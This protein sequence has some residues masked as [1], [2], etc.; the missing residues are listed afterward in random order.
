GAPLRYEPPSAEMQARA[1]SMAA[2]VKQEFPAGLEK[3]DEPL[4]SFV[5]ELESGTA[6]AQSVPSRFS[7][8]FCYSYF[9]LYGDPL[10]ERDADPHPEG[11]LRKLAGTGVDG[12]WLQA[13]LSKLAPFPWDAKMSTRHEER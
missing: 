9:A 1:R 7:P 4:F 13:V 5:K 12:V 10:L 3:Q 6:S 8:K 2:L 11:Y